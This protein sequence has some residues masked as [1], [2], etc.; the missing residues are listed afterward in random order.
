MTFRNLTI[1]SLLVLTQIS[2]HA[3]EVHDAFAESRKRMV[4]RDLVR[5]GINDPRILCAMSLVPRHLFVPSKH[6]SQAYQDRPVPIGE[7]QTISQP[8]VVALMTELLKLEGNEKVLE[9]GTG[10]G[11]QAAVLS[12]LVKEVYSIEIIPSLAESAQERLGRLGYSNVKVKS[13]DGYFGW[14]EKGPFDGI[15]VTAATREIPPPQWSQ[16]QEGGRLVMPLGDS[17]KPQMLVRVLKIDGKPQ[18]ETITGV[19]F[20]PMTGEAQEGTP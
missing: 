16:L 2:V 3:Q 8:Y 14:E 5:R 19:I 20:V 10:S 4:E 15:V 18:V 13:A 1:L 9:V 7:R 17:P 6:Q 12:L 11:Y